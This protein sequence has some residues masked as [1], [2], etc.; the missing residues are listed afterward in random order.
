[1]FCQPSG[2]TVK[3]FLK[4]HADNPFT[5]IPLYGE[6][7]EEI[8]GYVLKQHIFQ[9]QVRG[10]AAKTLGDFQRSL[11]VM[12]ETQQ[13]SD[14]FDQLIHSKSHITLVIDEY[15]SPEGLVTLE[16]VIET[17]IGLEITDELDTVEDMQA[18]ARTRWKKR[19][20]TLGIDPGDWAK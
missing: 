14:A 13:A 20:V 18:L 2:K 6:H 15:G 5:R 10:E 11:P 8:T 16:D 9:A 12:P 4:E 1:M 3:D 19:M 17:L 7:S